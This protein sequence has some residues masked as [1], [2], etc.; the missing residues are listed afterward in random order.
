MTS[1]EDRKLF[2]CQNIEFVL[3]QEY[4]RNPAMTDAICARALDNAKIGCKH[5]FGFAQNETM[6]GAE[7]IRGIVLVCMA[8]A[9]KQV[10]ELETVTLKE[11]VACLEKIRRSVDRHA[12]G[13][14]GG[15]S[16]Y[17][18]VRHYLP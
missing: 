18:F 11:Y 17:E 8:I 10:G 1:M 13:G 6:S 7:E 12:D 4:E 3:K 2:I 15:R 16:Y 14:G 5:Q 9:Q